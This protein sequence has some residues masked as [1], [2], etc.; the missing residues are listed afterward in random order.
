MRRELREHAGDGRRGTFVIADAPQWV[1][2]LP[3]TA[4][5]S[6]ILVEQFRHG[7]STN[8]FEIPGGVVHGDEPLVLAAEREC[9]EETGWGSAQPARQIGILDPNPAFQSNTCTVFIW[10][11]CKPV[12]KQ[13]LDP[14][15]DIAV[16]EVSISDFE[17]MIADG[18]IRHSLVVAAYALFRL[19]SK[20]L[21]SSGRY[22]DGTR[23]NHG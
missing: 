1:N 15:E 19:Q 13:Q 11:G 3:I 10:E 4:Y 14:N 22:P 20:H 21:N 8:T 12:R 9:L 16:H 2:I 23:D 7:T 5:G 18:R 17:N 6:I